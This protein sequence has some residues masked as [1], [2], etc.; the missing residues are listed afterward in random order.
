[1]EVY[2]VDLGYFTSL[3]NLMEEANSYIL[4]YYP[5]IRNW[6][7]LKG[8]EIE[9]KGIYLKDSDII[10]YSYIFSPSSFYTRETY[11]QNYIMWVL[12][13]LKITTIKD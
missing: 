13:N 10:N 1:M 6:L 3:N 4:E 12:R 8:G 9:I 11:Q 2:K 7:S 5:K